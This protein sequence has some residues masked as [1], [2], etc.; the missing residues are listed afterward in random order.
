M[1]GSLVDQIRNANDEDK[2]QE[3]LE[4]GLFRFMDRGQQQMAHRIW[5]SIRDSL[6][7][8]EIARYLEE[9]GYGKNH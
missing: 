8:D 3:L 2:A 6:D 7:K 4:D 5:I 1:K 9:S